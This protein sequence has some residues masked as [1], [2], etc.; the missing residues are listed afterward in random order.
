MSYSVLTNAVDVMELFAFKSTRIFIYPTRT[1]LKN[2]RC[3]LNKENKRLLQVPKKNKSLCIADFK[4]FK[5]KQKNAH[6]DTLFF[7]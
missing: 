7:N 5:T 2:F 3:A 6:L 1:F 4:R